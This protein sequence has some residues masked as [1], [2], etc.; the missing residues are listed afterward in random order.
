MITLVRY[1]IIIVLTS[2][3]TQVA[4]PFDPLPPGTKDFVGRPYPVGRVNEVTKDSI[5][6]EAP[7][8]TYM[9]GVWSQGPVRVLKEVKTVIP[10]QPPKRFLVSTT[11]AAGGIPREPRNVNTPGRGYNVAEAEMYRLTDVM[12]GDWVTIKYSRVG[13]VDICDHIMIIKR[14]GGRVPPLPPGVERPRLSPA[15]PPLHHEVMNAHWDKIDKDNPHPE[16]LGNLRP[17]AEVLGRLA[18]APRLVRAYEVVPAA[19][20]VTSPGRRPSGPSR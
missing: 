19:R 9:K 11:L 1:S 5:T 4:W 7:G 16:K 8:Y 3:M 12:E 6:I 10:D 13:G 2:T 15:L 18:P 20:E 17:L 14:P